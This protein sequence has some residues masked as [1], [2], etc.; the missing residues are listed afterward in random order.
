[1]DAWKAFVDRPWLDHEGAVVGYQRIKP[2]NPFWGILMGN[3]D[4]VCNV[5]YPEN[6]G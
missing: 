1:M 2:Q 4:C 3:W 5:A 6:P